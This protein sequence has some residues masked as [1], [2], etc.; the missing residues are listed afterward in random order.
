MKKA[1]WGECLAEG[2]GTFILIFIGVGTV[3]SMVTAGITMSFWELS[4]A[5]GLAVTIAIYVAGFISGAHIN[6]AVTIGLAVWGGFDKKK[7]IP[8]IIS[9]IIGAFL[10]AAVVYGLYQEAIKI[11]EKTKGIIRTADS[12]WA[13]AGIFSTFPKSYL[14][15]FEAFC[16]EFAITALLMIVIF[17]VTDNDNGAA[18]KAGLPALAIGI[19][20]AICGI[21]FGPLTGF[22]MNPA[23]DFGPRLFLIA[24]GWG[25]N[26]LGP[27]MYGLIVPIFGP[28]IG[29]LFGGGVY[30][31]LIVPFFPKPQVEP[32]GK[33]FKK[34]S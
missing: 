20:I 19:T 10:G 16:V 2:I 13:S 27:H 28:I 25:T 7:V 18:P 33:D 30:K 22:A 14:T 12:G 4:I 9:Q 11:F 6:P 29:A 34:V 5:W 32:H 24:A 8:Y 15:T 23:R 26:V 1:L 3:A 21:S 31:K 17:A